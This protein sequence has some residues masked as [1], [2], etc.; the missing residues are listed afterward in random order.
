[1]GIISI[2][3]TD[4]L[5][6]LGR[7][8]ERV[9]TTIKLFAESYDDMIDHYFNSYNDF[10]ARLDIP[11]VYAS[12]DNF[13]EQ[14]CFDEADPNSIY[15]NLIRAYDNCVTLR[16][17]LGSDVVS[18]IQLAVYEMQHARVSHAP[19][20]DLQKVIDNIVAFWGMA[21][22][23]IN[24]QNV[25]NIIK[26]GKRVERLDLYARLQMPRECMLCEIH[27]LA[28]RIQQTCLHYQEAFLKEIEDTIGQDS[29]D[30]PS[31][32]YKVEHLLTE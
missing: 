31:I 5:Y 17:E 29:I 21:D 10:C 19:L 25:R 28:G 32:V 23:S 3:N 26:T 8:S 30:Y 16:E 22:D 1:M 13:I 2:E 20:I 12:K 18:Y 9:Y 6:W 11:N 15:S 24:S 14:Y 7:Y 4:R 27:R